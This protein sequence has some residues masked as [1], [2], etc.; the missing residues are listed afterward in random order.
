[1]SS[2]GTLALWLSPISASAARRCPESQSLVFTQVTNGWL[3][4]ASVP[5]RIFFLDV[6]WQSPDW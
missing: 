2:K 3:V 6:A 5:Q 4:F 1:M